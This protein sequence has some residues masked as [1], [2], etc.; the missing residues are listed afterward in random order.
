MIKMSHKH[1]LMIIAC[2]AVISLFVQFIYG[3]S[4]GAQIIITIMGAYFVLVML[5]EMIQTIRH[6]QYGVDLLAILAIVSTLA[7]GEHWAALI[8]LI[9]LVG[10]DALEDYAT[11]KANTELKALLDNS[12]QVAY[13]ITGDQITTITVNE[14]AVGDQLLIK[15]GEVVP[16]DGWSL[17]VPQPLMNHR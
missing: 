12:P 16:V 17:A 10:G 4:L 13:R 14:V 7:V 11:N 2:V 15:P 3:S 9:M 5:A 6:G 1:I 8:I